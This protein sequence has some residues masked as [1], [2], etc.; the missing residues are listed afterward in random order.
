MQVNSLIRTPK[1]ITGTDSN[2]ISAL[3]AKKI[4]GFLGQPARTKLEVRILNTKF[5]L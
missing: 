4:L 2:T 3:G 5:R 1:N